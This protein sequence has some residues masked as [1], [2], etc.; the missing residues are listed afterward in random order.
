MNVPGQQVRFRWLHH[1]FRELRF[2]IPN[3]T[4]SAIDYL[5][6]PLF[7]VVLRCWSGTP[8][9]ES[10]VTP[11]SVWSESYDDEA[12]LKVGLGRTLRPANMRMD[13]DFA[14]DDEM[15]GWRRFADEVE[16]AEAIVKMLQKLL[17]YE[18]C[19]PDPEDEE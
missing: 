11:M 2:T 6:P 14:I 10:T 16:L 13:P 17:K 18:G 3:L 4:V 19:R 8:I 12:A 1:A 5:D 15:G 9:I 7:S